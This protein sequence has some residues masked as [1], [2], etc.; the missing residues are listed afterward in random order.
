MGNIGENI[1][2]CREKRGLSQEQLADMIGKTRSAVSQYE[3]GKIIPRMGVIEDM[4]DALGVKKTEL[5]SS[6]VS[7]FMVD[8]DEA[9]D[10]DE[11]EVVRCMRHMD[12]AQRSLLIAIACEFARKA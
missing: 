4:A 3:S 5:T 1:K 2:R 8:V 12:D 7:Y 6:T 11:R 10:Y 9:L